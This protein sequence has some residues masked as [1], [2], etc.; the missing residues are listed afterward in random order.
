MGTLPDADSAKRKVRRKSAQNA[1]R[2]SVGFAMSKNG[3]DLPG[4]RFKRAKSNISRDWNPALKSRLTHVPR[5]SIT[6]SS[7][8]KRRIFVLKTLS[9]WY[10]H[11]IGNEGTCSMRFPDIA[12]LKWW[13]GAIGSCLTF[14]STI[15][16]Y[17]NISGRSLGLFFDVA[18]SQYS[19]IVSVI[20]SPLKLL[21]D[22]T[23]R[24]KLLISIE[25]IFVVAVI[26]VYFSGEEEIRNN[27]R[28]SIATS[29]VMFIFIIFFLFIEGRF[30]GYD[31]IVIA[32]ILSIFYLT[33]FSGFFALRLVLFEPHMLKT[34]GLLLANLA[35]AILAVGIG[36]ALS[37]PSPA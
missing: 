37:I 31:G 26:K 6:E 8:E 21:I 9:G 28:G 27:I 30:V 3:P 16:L 7:D 29:T 32:T 12:P 18:M 22:I 33:C 15:C 19:S 36:T 2:A 5:T 35:S 4:H 20:F 23:D 24:E 13:Y 17:K 11:V 1:V 25:T 10:G 14:A 34:A